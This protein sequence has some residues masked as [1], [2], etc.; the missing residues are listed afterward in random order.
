MEYTLRLQRKPFA[1]SL[2]KGEWPTPKSKPPG[3]A[4]QQAT[5]FCFAKIK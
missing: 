1:L 3:V 4:R 5:F 2:S